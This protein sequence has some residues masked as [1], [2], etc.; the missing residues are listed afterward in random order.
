MFLP[1]GN[2]ESHESR[3]IERKKVRKKDMSVKEP[4]AF[5]SHLQTLPATLWQPVY[6][7]ESLQSI[8]IIRCL[9]K[10]TRR[11]ITRGF[12]FFFFRSC[13]L[14]VMSVCSCKITAVSSETGQACLLSTWGLRCKNPSVENPRLCES[15]G[16]DIECEMLP[17]GSLKALVLLLKQP[18]PTPPSLRLETVS[19]LLRNAY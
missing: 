14:D 13:M 1:S 17:S 6:A 9:T 15:N 11:L 4:S 2:Q 8:N 5:I 19:V 18:R 7:T 3:R 16:P 10:N 12:F